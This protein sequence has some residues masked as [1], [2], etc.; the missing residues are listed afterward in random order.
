MANTNKKLAVWLPFTKDWTN[1]GVDT[2]GTLS[3]SNSSIVNNGKLGKCL[4]ITGSGTSATFNSLKNLT[5]FS[6]ALWIRNDATSGYT[7]WADIIQLTVNETNGYMNN[8]AN[9]TFRIERSNAD[10]PNSFVCYFNYYQNGTNASTGA[11]TYTSCSAGTSIALNTWKHVVMTFDGTTGKIYF[12]G[13]TPTSIKFSDRKVTNYKLVGNVM[14]GGENNPK[15]SINDFRIYTYALSEQEV[16]ELAKG[17]VCH[18]PLDEYSGTSLRNKYEGISAEGRSSNDPDKTTV[19][20]LT[21]ERGY[22]YKVNFISNTTST[23]YYP[24]TWSTF[25][26]TAGKTY[27]YSCDVR[28]NSCST[29]YQLYMRPSRVN[30]DW[31]TSPQ[32][33]VVSQSK[34]GKGWIHYNSAIV[35]PANFTRD[36]TTI[37]SQPLMQFYNNGGQTSKPAGTSWSADFDIRNIQVVESDIEVPFI[38][39]EAC[40]YMHD[41]SG[42]HY[43]L[44]PTGN[45]SLSNDT[46]RY[47]YSCNCMANT[48][49]YFTS[50]NIGIST[51]NTTLSF[52]YKRTAASSGQENLLNASGQLIIWFRDGQWSPR[53]RAYKSGDSNTY[54]GETSFANASTA[55]TNWCHCAAVINGKSIKLYYNGTPLTEQTTTNDINNTLTTFTLATAKILISDFRIYAT[56]L[57][58]ADIKQLYALGN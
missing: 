42:N 15:S 37:T 7:N 57:S 30:N 41:I 50:P 22:N 52:W 16:K 23:Q 49:S 56:A 35:I 38:Y 46:K 33:T 31:T 12:D 6:I 13:G 5:Q 48:S 17:K 20:K 25:N 55:N 24:L 36:G 43:D 8:T 45:I 18:Y 53:V 32:Q 51:T 40:G 10:N 1:Q 28:V 29:E 2:S 58:E 34:V 21:N 9:S 54:L 4:Q 44:T 3:N 11:A 27:Q 26:F 47:K 14:I 39:N 19:T